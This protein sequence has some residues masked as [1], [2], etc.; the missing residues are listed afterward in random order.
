MLGESGRGRERKGDGNNRM[1]A[2]RVIAPLVP[3]LLQCPAAS[4]SPLP[5]P[6]PCRL[7]APQ[8]PQD[9]ATPACWWLGRRRRRPPR[10]L[11]RASPGLVRPA[12]MW[13]RKRARVSTA[14]QTTGRGAPGSKLRT[15]HLHLHRL[16]VLAGR[17][18]A[19]VEHRHGLHRRVVPARV[20]RS[21]RPAGAGPDHAGRSG[22]GRHRTFSRE[23]A[24]GSCPLGGGGNGHAP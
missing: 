15:T 1:H 5:A 24:R 11:C 19:G 16:A 2:Y 21:L 4:C 17:L 23:A 9:P 7:L 13:S 3:R 18:Q 10:G 8:P 22:M 6:L 20:E 14:T 12:P